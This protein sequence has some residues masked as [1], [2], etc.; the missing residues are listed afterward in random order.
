MGI[1]KLMWFSVG[2]AAA[3]GLGTYVLFGSWLLWLAAFLF[4]TTGI[5]FFIPSRAGKTAAITLLG[6]LVGTLWFWGFDSYYLSP[7]RELDGKDAVCSITVSDY[8]YE[9]DYGVA[10]EGKVRLSG[11][12]YSVL[13]YLPQEASLCPG[14]VLSGTFH[15]RYTSRGGEKEVTYHPGKGIFLLAYGDEDASITPGDEKQPKY[16]AVRARKQILSILDETFP[17]ATKGFAKALLLGDSSDLS[18]KAD[19]DFQVSGIRHVIAVS[20]L[21]VSILFSLIYGVIGYRRVLLTVIGIPLLILFAAVAGFTPSIVRACILQALVILAM[22]FDSE[23][24]PPTALAF[25]VLTMLAVNPLTISSVSFQLSVGCMIGIFAFSERISGYIFSRKWARGGK[26]ETVR[27]RLTRWFTGSV[28]VT[29]SAMVVTIPLCAI[30]FESI[31]ILGILTNLLTLW[32]VSFIFYGIMAVCLLGMLWPG[33]AQ[34]VAWIISLP[35]YFVMGMARAIA[36]IPFAAVYTD[37]VYIVVWLILSYVL[38]GLF[39]WGKCRHPKTLAACILG[40]LG[41]A[42]A[43]SWIEPRMD[44]FR[45][46]VMDVGQGQCVLLQYSGRNVLVDCG[47]DYPEKAADM[48]AKQLLSQGVFHL[49]GVV[50]SHYDKDHSGGVP[51]LLTRVP[52]DRLYLPKPEENE[53][54]KEHL[55]Q[56]HKGDT[57][58]LSDMQ[59]LTIEEIPITL[60]AGDGDESDNESSICVLFQ[61]ENCDILI[62][63]DRGIAGERKLLSQLA[64]PKLELLV[65]GHHGAKQSTGLELLQAT[66]PA[67]VIISAGRNNRHGHPAQEVLDRL[68]LYRCQLWRTDLQGTIIFTGE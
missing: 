48:A 5:L 13:V 43:L 49:D 11:K 34:T 68:E 30:Y 39:F 37:S 16:F 61:P 6:M 57:V 2:F 33:I 28:S 52:A 59:I 1:R 51:Y 35:M 45:V 67:Q 3:C 64:L 56:N 27:A 55:I 53:T 65:A 36:S 31:S 25:A 23:Y 8:S 44:Q 26:G 58:F 66:R 54:V 17:A 9:T 50:V 29:L 41:A 46:T 32:V 18:Y 62:T 63:G 4:I 10:A 21:H 19:V 47:G 14:D 24:D 42:I 15:F 40:L 60:I 22:L 12:S 7:P 38:L 20:G